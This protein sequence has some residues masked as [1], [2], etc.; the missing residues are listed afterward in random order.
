MSRPSC[1]PSL[2]KTTRVSVKER[3]LCGVT[4]P[5]AWDAEP[6]PCFKI[7]WKKTT[8]QRSHHQ[9]G[10]WPVA[11]LGP[12]TSAWTCSRP[13]CDPPSRNSSNCSAASKHQSEYSTLSAA[14]YS[15]FFFLLGTTHSLDST[16]PTRLNTAE[17]IGLFQQSPKP[18]P[19]FARPNRRD[20]D[21]PSSSPLCRGQPRP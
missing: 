16:F 5:L 10:Q 9:A 8:A 6:A 19:R 14:P 21:A 2:E 4:F 7:F 18:P 11:A 20:P 1:C 15:S 17:L 3:A 12:P 13:F